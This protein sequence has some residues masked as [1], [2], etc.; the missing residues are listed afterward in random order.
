MD[1][2]GEWGL[3]GVGVAVL[4]GEAPNECVC[5]VAGC[6]DC[7]GC[8]GVE[9]DVVWWVPV[10]GYSVEVLYAGGCCVYVAGSS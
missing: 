8:A 1:V 10:V 3:D 9:E 6:G 2:D 7:S 5:D 4:A